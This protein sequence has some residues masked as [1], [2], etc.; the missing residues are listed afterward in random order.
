[1]AATSTNGATATNAA[2]AAAANAPPTVVPAPSAMA[3]TNVYEPGSVNKLV[4]ISAA[5]QLGIVRAS[6]H[7]SV[8]DSTEVG[9][10]V[11]HDA[12]PHPVENWTTTDILANSSNV[13]TIGIAQRLGKTSINQ[14]LRAFGFGQTTDIHFPGESAGLLLDPAKW[15]GT[16]IATVPIGQGVAVTAVQMLAAYNTVANGGVY[17]APKLIAATVD[18]K[19][20]QHATP[21]SARRQV[22]SPGVAR[23]MTAM[24]GQVV[25]VGTGMEA[26]ISGYTVA[27]KTGTARIPLDGARG[28]KDGVYASSFAGFV[29]AERPALTGIV[30]LDETAQFGGT[31]AAPVFASIARYGLQEFRI[32]PPPPA[33]LPP[34]VPQAT[35]ANA[36]GA[37]EK[38]PPTTQ[39]PAT[40]VPAAAAGSSPA[41][42]GSSPSTRA[43]T[44]TTIARPPR[45]VPT[46]P[47]RTA[48]TVPPTAGRIAPTTATTAPTTTPTTR[49][50]KR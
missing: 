35:S 44:P 34:G 42:P 36:Q 7:F 37:G 30:I 46:V 49:L 3:F 9:G 11:F 10:T 50:L 33:P 14:Y 2:T 8:P 17:V 47:S 22:V 38:L 23:D 18:A 12:E 41:A 16:S 25:K 15:S 45:S 48:T 4:T 31:V 1:M 39:A 6:D 28:Y 21:P 40:T 29:P 32:P 20:R 43:G 24:L 19:G 13:G 27:G 26:A 5:L